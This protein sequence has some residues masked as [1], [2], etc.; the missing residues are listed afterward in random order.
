[1]ACGNPGVKRTAGEERRIAAGGCPPVRLP[2]PQDRSRSSAC[3]R[4][5]HRRGC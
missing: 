1:M 4:S 3:R 5:Q 2:H